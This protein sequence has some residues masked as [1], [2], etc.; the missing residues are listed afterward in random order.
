MSE[1]RCRDHRILDQPVCT[2]VHQPRPDAEGGRIHREYIPQLGDLIDPGFDL[3]RLLILL[4][5]D[6]DASLKLAECHRGE[7]ELIGRRAFQ[8]SDHRAMRL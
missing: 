5:R 2:A 1:R 4:A 7:V 6:L 3:L 8:P